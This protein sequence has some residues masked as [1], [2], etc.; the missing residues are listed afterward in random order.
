MHEHTKDGFLEFM[1]TKCRR[2]FI[3]PNCQASV[4]NLVDKPVLRSLVLVV[5]EPMT[6][7]GES[8]VANPHCTLFMQDGPSPVLLVRVELG[9]M[10]LGIAFNPLCPLTRQY[11]SD[12]ATGGSFNISLAFVE[13]AHTALQCGCGF[14]SVSVSSYYFRFA[15]DETSNVQ[16]VYKIF[17]SES[18]LPVMADFMIEQLER[19]CNGRDGD[20]YFF[21]VAQEPPFGAATAQY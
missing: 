17:W 12:C 10:T 8:P 15:L 21:E 3:V 9:E 14:A 2:A 13:Q 4:E 6:L 18:V 7:S 16:P 20:F 11:L 5:D 1:R 19:Q